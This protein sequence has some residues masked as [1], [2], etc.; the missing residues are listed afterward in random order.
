MSENE[1]QKAPDEG[2]FGSLSAGDLARIEGALYKC[3]SKLVKTPRTAPEW[4]I[5][6]LYDVHRMIF[7]DVFPDRAGR[8]RQ[9]MVSIRDLP[10]PSVGQISYR[11]DTVVH[12]IRDLISKSEHLA[13]EEKVNFVF[14]EAARIHADCVTIQPFIDGNKRWAREVL[15]A[16]LTD[17]GFYPGTE[18]SAADHDRYMDG[19]SKSVL[20]GYPEQ[21]GNLILGGWLAQ[22]QL[23]KQGLR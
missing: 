6:F 12:A 4:S 19:I 9:V 18:I 16:I 22:R 20:G 2:A 8:E 23:Y 3:R 15:S 7:A 17:C 10:V 14:T 11:L 21:L 13:G 5:A 1:I